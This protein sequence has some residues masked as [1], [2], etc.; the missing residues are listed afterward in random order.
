M[1]QAK[2]IAGQK[3][4]LRTKDLHAIEFC[5]TCHRPLL[6]DYYPRIGQ[7]GGLARLRAIGREGMRE[8][9]KKGGRGNVAG[10]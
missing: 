10:R 4:G 2:A 6:N 5:P 1:N 3:G 7:L 8:M 9:G